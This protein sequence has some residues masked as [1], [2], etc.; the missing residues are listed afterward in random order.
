M[1]KLE[2]VDSSYE[3][4]SEHVTTIEFPKKEGIKY[5]LSCG[6]ECL[7]ESDMCLCG[8]DKF[9]A[10]D[11]S[12]IIGGYINQVDKLRIWYHK[13]YN[14]NSIIKMNNKRIIYYLLTHKHKINIDKKIV[15]KIYNTSQ[16]EIGINN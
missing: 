12:A 7:S 4:H 11:A 9:L 6:N 13:H 5:C 3:R 10:Q 1:A 2:T 14:T 8:K 16:K 15:D